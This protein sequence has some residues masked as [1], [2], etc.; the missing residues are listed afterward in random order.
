M[1]GTKFVGVLGVL[2]RKYHSVIP[3][4]GGSGVGISRL[5][6]RQ[7]EISGGKLGEWDPQRGE[8]QALRKPDFAVRSAKGRQKRNTYPIF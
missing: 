3:C 2:A 5:V 6:S 8:K 7:A 1:S 4:L